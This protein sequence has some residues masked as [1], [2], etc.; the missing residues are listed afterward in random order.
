MRSLGTRRTVLAAAAAV[1]ASAVVAGCSAGQVAETSLK[2][3]SN[4]GVNVNNSDN[5]VLIRNLAVSYNGPMGYPAN[6]S[7]PLELG[8]YNQTQQEVIVNIS[9]TRPTDGSADPDV[10]TG[11]SVGL[12]G[13]PAT[14]SSTAIPEPSGSRGPAVP[15]TSEGPNAGVQ[16]TS[17]APSVEPTISAAPSEAAQP[18]RIVLGPLGSATFLPGDKQSLQVQGLSGRLMPGQ[19]VYV[20]FEFSNGAQQLTV[21]VAVTVPLTPAS[22][23][24]VNPSE[25]IEP[26]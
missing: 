6:S 7:A 2:R 19:S 24:P 10:I 9:S 20:T 4:Q 26:E 23:G 15:E 18:A 14:P 12:V 13:G 11:T 22:R 5:S 25:N 3:P 21:P 17:A 1:L 16:G 8:L